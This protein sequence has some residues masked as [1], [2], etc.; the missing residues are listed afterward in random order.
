MKARWLEKPQFSM[1]QLHSH[2]EMHATSTKG[3]GIFDRE[4]ISRLTDKDMWEID[5]GGQIYD[6]LR[7]FTLF[8]EN[9]RLDH[10]TDEG[11]LPEGVLQSI[12]MGASNLRQL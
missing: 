10:L 5:T 12:E 8:F 6:Y 2:M 7:S 11:V 3:Y 4:K 1:I 9:R